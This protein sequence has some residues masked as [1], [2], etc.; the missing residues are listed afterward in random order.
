MKRAQEVCPIAAI[1][2]QYSMVW[3]EPEKEIFDLSEEMGI[4]FVA[5][6]PLGNGFLSGNLLKNHSLFQFQVQPI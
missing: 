1:E 4:A 3:G 2:N 5:Y 6:S